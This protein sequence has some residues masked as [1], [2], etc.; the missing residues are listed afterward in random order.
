[1]TTVDRR[2]SQSEIYG[3]ILISHCVLA[4]VRELRRVAASIIPLVVI[5]ISNVKL[6]IRAISI[7]ANQGVRREKWRGYGRQL[8]PLLSRRIDVTQM[9]YLV[10]AAW[11]VR[12]RGTA[13][14]AYSV[15][16][17]EHH[18]EF[19]LAAGYV[20]LPWRSVGPRPMRPVT[21]S[22]ACHPLARVTLCL[23][24]FTLQSRHAFPPMPS[25]VENGAVQRA[26]NLRARSQRPLAGF[27]TPRF[28]V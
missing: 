23:V 8:Q 19:L 17:A 28:S 22:A 11:S 27:R 12:Y 26:R 14:A 20:H 24:P 18:A 3:S 1:V 25:T 13:T 10:C 16:G 6:S 7:P 15:R 5:I 9:T 4:R 2:N 21:G